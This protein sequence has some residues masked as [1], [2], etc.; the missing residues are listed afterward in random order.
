MIPIRYV[1]NHLLIVEKP[2]GMLSQADRTGDEDILTLM[3]AWVGEQFNK[4]GN[5]YLGLVHRLDRPASGLMALARTSKA[6]ARLSDQFKKRTVEKRYLAWIEGQTPDEATWQDHLVKRDQTVQIV[7]SS[8]TQGKRASL[9]LRTIASEAGRSLVVVRLHTGRP[10]QIRVQFASR[11][12]PLVGDLRY[13]AR[14][15][16]DGRNLALHAAALALDHPTR[17]DRLGWTALPPNS[18]PNRLRAQ[19]AKWLDQWQSANAYPDSLP[20]L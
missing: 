10:H 19:S 2:A 18:W 7:D 16:L 5:V 17:S 8:T 3:K 1:D 14:S 6:A 15:E 9:D 20:P 13:G 12:Y 4:P 11:G